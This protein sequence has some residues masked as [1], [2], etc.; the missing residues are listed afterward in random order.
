MNKTIKTNLTTKIYFQIKKIL[1]A[2]F[3]IL[4][5]ICILFCL[6]LLDISGMMITGGTVLGVH[7]QVYCQRCR[8]RPAYCFYVSSQ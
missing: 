1:I 3:E 7:W 6:I 5:N 8:Q 2:V 4:T